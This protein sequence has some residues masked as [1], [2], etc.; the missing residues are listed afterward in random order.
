MTYPITISLREKLGTDLSSR[1]RA[2]GFRNEI[3]SL[4]Q[5][6]RTT[7]T[8]NL[9]GVCTVSESFADELFGILVKQNG[10][11]WFREHIV[12]QA[13]SPD[14]RYSILSAVERRIATT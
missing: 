5:I 7:V 8:L 1:R 6:G 10:E 13:T 12:L 3:I 2:A 14:V 11:D 4:I 9:D